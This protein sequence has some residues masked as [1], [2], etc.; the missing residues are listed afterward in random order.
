MLFTHMVEKNRFIVLLAFKPEGDAI[1][2]VTVASLW[3]LRPVSDNPT[4]EALIAAPAGD[5][6]TDAVGSLGFR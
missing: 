2:G 3:T 1:S 5:Q 4:H 6:P